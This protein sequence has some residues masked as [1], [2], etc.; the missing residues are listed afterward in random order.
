MIKNTDFTVKTSR[1]F[2][3]K[4]AGKIEPKKNQPNN[5]FHSY[6]LDIFSAKLSRVAKQKKSF[7]ESELSEI[8]DNTYYTLCK[9]IHSFFDINFLWIFTG[10]TMRK[11]KKGKRKNLSFQKESMVKK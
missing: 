9:K 5:E 7:E 1:I 10:K 3:F 6:L 11:N 8:F 2:L 4:L